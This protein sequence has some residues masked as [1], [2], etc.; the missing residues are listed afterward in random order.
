MPIVPDT[1]DWTWVL[2]RPCP[3]CGFDSSTLDVD[4]VS[5]MVRSNAAA[6][7]D[8]LADERA[9]RR[10]SDDV[11]SALEYGCHVRDVFRLYDERLQLML[12]KDD[13][14]FPNWDQDVTA[15][16]QHYDRQSPAK[17]ADELESAAFE[18]AARFQVVSGDQWARTGR[19]SDGAV[20]TV[21]TF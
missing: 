18:L 13:P 14:P 19:R 7:R 12:A 3:E 17:V 8:V 21:E 5:E 11:W 1:K 16:E 6:W 15:I 9:R 2:Q 10:P 20:F 4:Q